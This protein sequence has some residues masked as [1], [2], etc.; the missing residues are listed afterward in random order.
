MTGASPER[1][2]LRASPQSC[3]LS[4]PLPSWSLASLETRPPGTLDLE[5]VFEESWKDTWE[6][7][8]RADFKLFDECAWEVASI[9]GAQVLG[10][11][12]QVQVP[13]CGSTQVR[14]P[15]PLLVVR[16]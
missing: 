7:M 13:P 2:L 3:D 11:L 12:A 15:T 5:V 9:N 14:L 6:P 1:S 8:M 10:D 4:E 16:G